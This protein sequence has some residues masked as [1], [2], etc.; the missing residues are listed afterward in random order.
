MFLKIEL[1]FRKPHQYYIIDTEKV[2]T[3][4]VKFSNPKFVQTY[5]LFKEPMKDFLFIL[6][7]SLY[8]THPNLFTNE[9]P[10]KKLIFTVQN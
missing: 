4:K 10:S 2:K 3:L 9:L 1:F 6:Q 5:L 8:T 7:Q